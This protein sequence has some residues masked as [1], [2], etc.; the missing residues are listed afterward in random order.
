MSR[1]QPF[2]IVS[3]QNYGASIWFRLVSLSTFMRYLSKLATFVEPSFIY[4]LPVGIALMFDEQ[5][6]SDAHYKKSFAFFQAQNLAEIFTVRFEPSIVES[7]RK[8]SRKI[9]IAFLEIVF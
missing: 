6:T 8:Q 4:I 3:I 7:K 5:T 9:S 1:H 2:W